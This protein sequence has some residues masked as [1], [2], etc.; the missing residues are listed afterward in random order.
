MWQIMCAMLQVV[1][2]NPKEVRDFIRT[3]LI[4]FDFQ[5]LVPVPEHIA[6]SDEKV[7]WEGMTATAWVPWS[8]EHWGATHNARDARSFGKAFFRA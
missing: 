5:K 8:V 2:G 3:D 7:E 6:K 4:I 1:K